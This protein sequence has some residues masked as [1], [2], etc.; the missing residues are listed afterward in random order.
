MAFGDRKPEQLREWRERG[1]RNYQ[2]NRRERAEQIA[3]GTERVGLRS[4]PR[5]LKPPIP[6]SVKQRARA[7]SGGKCIVCLFEG[8]N[9]PGKA[10]DPHHVFTERHAPAL[11][12]HESNLVGVCRHHHLAHHNAQPRIPL[13][14]LPDCVFELARSLGSQAM[15]YLRRYYGGADPRLDLSDDL[16]PSILEGQARDPA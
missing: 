10:Q 7:R 11:R 13:A 5:P 2:R 12:E 8:R 9:R 15:H 14:A 1:A 3:P 6:S 4:K 16:S